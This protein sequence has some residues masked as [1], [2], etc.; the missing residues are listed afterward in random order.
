MSEDKFNFNNVERDLYKALVSVLEFAKQMADQASMDSDQQ[1]FVE[2]Q[3]A[4]DQYEWSL[5][6]L[7]DWASARNLKGE[8]VQCAQLYT[9][10]GRRNGNGVV[11]F[12]TT[13]PSADCEVYYHVIT[14]S[15][16]ELRLSIQELIELFEVGDFIMKENHVLLM[17]MRLKD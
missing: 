5:G 7:P 4:L 16:N 11:A 12:I 8:L 10:N 1:E 15:G 17:K 6:P 3:F 2:A 9:K 13:P 14:D